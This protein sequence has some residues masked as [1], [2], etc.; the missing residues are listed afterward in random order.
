MVPITNGPDTKQNR[1][2][3]EKKVF[4]RR[5]KSLFR[6]AIQMNS[7]PTL[8]YKKSNNAFNTDIQQLIEK[9]HCIHEQTLNKNRCGYTRWEIHIKF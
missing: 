5:P 4:D 2:K 7:D 3:I 8:E 1:N 9:D 6:S